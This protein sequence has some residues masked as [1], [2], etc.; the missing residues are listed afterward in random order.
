[1]CDVLRSNRTIRRL[2]LDGNRLNDDC[3]PFIAELIAQNDY[4]QYLNLSKNFFESELTG[5]LLG[6]ALGENQTIEQFFIA[7]NRLRPKSCANFVKPL[8][9]NARLIVLDLSWNGGALQAAKYFTEI[10]RKNSSL[11]KLYLN[12]NQFNTECATHLG[13]GLAKNE[14]L[15]YLNVGGNPLE[16]SGGYAILSTLLQNSSSPIER[17][18]MIGIMPNQDLHEVIEQLRSVRPSLRINIYIDQ[19]FKKKSQYKK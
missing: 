6:Q 7:Y 15:K 14:T 2:L 5:R 10:L 18:D 3:S 16:S 13:R 1:M 9:S 19:L 12:N 4:I 8:I 11:E 17:I